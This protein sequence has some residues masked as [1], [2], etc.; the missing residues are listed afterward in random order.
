MKK[1]NK[2]YFLIIIIILIIDILSKFWILKYFDLYEKK[3]IFSI[4]N[5]FHVH[6]YGIAFSMFSNK[7]SW[8]RFFLSILS[9][10]IIVFIFKEIVKTKTNEKKT[11]LC[12]ILSGAIGNVIDRINYGFVIDFIDIHI[13]NWHFATFNISDCSIFFGM[14]MYIKKHIKNKF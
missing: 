14:I 13:N 6:N 12:F 4:L 3:E 11:D 1:I 5:L 2:K 9:I 7:T 8:N 10:I